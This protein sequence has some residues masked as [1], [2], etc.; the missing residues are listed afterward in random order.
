MNV[1]PPTRPTELRGRRV[2]LTTAE[3]L[4]ALWADM[5][6]T[7]GCVVATGPTSRRAAR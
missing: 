1:M 4:I 6:I 7:V 5:E 2:G 3:Q